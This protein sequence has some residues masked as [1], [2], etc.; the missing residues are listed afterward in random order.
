MV[1]RLEMQRVRRHVEGPQPLGLLPRFGT[2][3]GARSNSRASSL[4][5]QL[6]LC[7]PLTPGRLLQHPRHCGSRLTVPPD[8]ADERGVDGNL[9]MPDWQ[10]RRKDLDAPGIRHRDIKIHLSNADMHG[11][12]ARLP[13]DKRE[14]LPAQRGWPSSAARRTCDM[15]SICGAPAAAGAHRCGEQAAKQ[16]YAE[17]FV[18][19]PKLRGCGWTCRAIPACGPACDN[20]SAPPRRSARWPLFANRG[21]SLPAHSAP[22]HQ[23]R[24]TPNCANQSQ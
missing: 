1:I 6:R 11:N 7:P 12:H 5:L 2:G 15:V 21:G 20:S 13:R 17:Q 10:R 16:D 14:R 4:H 18:K 3:Y 19:Q 22:G 9:A 24:A 23:P 8:R